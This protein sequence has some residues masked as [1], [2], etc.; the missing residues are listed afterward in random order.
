MTIN[1]LWVAVFSVAVLGACG[2]GSASTTDGQEASAQY[3]GPIGS[4]DVARGQ[5]VFGQVCSGCHSDTSSFDQ[6]MTPAHVR[7]QIREGSGRMPP[8]REARVS[9]DDME[10]ILAYFA[11]FGAVTDEGGA[12]GG[13]GEAMPATAAETAADS[14]GEEPLEDDL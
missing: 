8:I 9:N 11:S 12:P 10:A 5:E 13:G 1:R 3:A 6:G 14:D 7:H 2:G 4:S